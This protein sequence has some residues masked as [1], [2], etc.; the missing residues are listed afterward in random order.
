MFRK[1]KNQ[2][3]DTKFTIESLVYSLQAM[4]T[5]NPRLSWDSPVVISD[6]QMSGFRNN[7]KLY[8]IN[9]Y[10]TGKIKLGLFILPN[11]LD[12]EFEGEPEIEEELKPNAEESLKDIG[13]DSELEIIDFTEDGFPELN[14]FPQIEKDTSWMKKYGV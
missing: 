8:P 11:D 13:D 1:K 12:S 7:F 4:M 3:C 2:K 10:E 6:L 14:D 9:D 5:E